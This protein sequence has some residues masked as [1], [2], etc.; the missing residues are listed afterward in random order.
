MYI[1]KELPENV[2]EW[3]VA[4]YKHEI[5]HT[6][7]YRMFDIGRLLLRND[8]KN[9]R[10]EQWR[11]EVTRIFDDRN[12]WMEPDPFGFA[13]KALDYH[14]PQLGRAVFDLDQHDVFDMLVNQELYAAQESLACRLSM[15]AKE[16]GLPEFAWHSTCGKGGEADYTFEVTYEPFVF[17]LNNRGQYTRKRTPG[18]EPT[19][20]TLEVV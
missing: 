13:L 17:S 8:L 3:V 7:R 16:Q 14:L 2:R 15:N 1:R 20:R 12:D 10:N 11:N 9:Y 6:L 4:E 19:P 5:Y 18:S